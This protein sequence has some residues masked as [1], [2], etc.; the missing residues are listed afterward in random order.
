V[1]AEKLGRNVKR[2]FKECVLHIGTEKTGSTTLQ[3]FLCENRRLFFDRGFFVPKSLSPYATLAN[4]ERLT[5]YALRDDKLNDDL[6]VAAGIKSI[7]QIHEHRKDV[8]ER[9][10]GELASETVSEDSI[11]LLSNEHCH[12]RLTEPSEVALLGQFLRSFSDAVR[13]VV[14]IRPQHELATSLHDQ[15]LKA[16]YFDID[17]LPF[18][19]T[20]KKQWVTRRYFQYDD[21]VKRWGAEFGLDN[22]T[23]R[24][25]DRQSL[26]GQNIIFDFLSLIGVP[27][28]DFKVISDK[29]RSIGKTF[30][31]ALNAINRFASENQGSVTPKLREK[32]IGI[33]SQANAEAGIKPARKDAESFYHA[34]DEG[35]EFVRKTFF[36][37]K[38]ALFDP[39]FSLFPVDNLPQPLDRDPLIKLILHILTSS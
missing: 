19:S 36:P 30:Q 35:N 4:H 24:I 27:S 15:A 13:I 3:A 21:L 17:V 5:T 1:R 32:L 6:R 12:S 29:N 26:L 23:V 31:Q 16:G 33:L 7:D 2:K 14:Y 8:L 11:L 22:L 25:F 37:E 20:S 34:Y 28:D 18:T 10:N 39:D 38:R 9:L